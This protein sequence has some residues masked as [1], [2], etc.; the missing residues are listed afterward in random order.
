[1]IAMQYAATNTLTFDIP[2]GFTGLDLV[3]SFLSM[4]GNEYDFDADFNI[5]SQTTDPANPPAQKKCGW[6]GCGI[7]VYSINTADPV[8]RY[9]L[10]ATTG[11]PHGTI[12]FKCIV[13]SLTWKSK[14]S[15]QWNAFTVG[16]VGLA[17]DVAPYG[18]PC[19]PVTCQAGCKDATGGCTYTN[20]FDT[21]LCDDNNVCTSGDICSNG[22]CQGT[23]NTDSCYDNDACT[24][25]DT[26][27]GGVCQG[28]TKDC[29]TPSDPQCQS[30]VGTCD[31]SSGD[32]SY[33]SLTDG[34]SCNAD[35]NACTPDAC[36]NGACTSGPTKDCNTPSDPQ[37]Q[38]N[39][40]TCDTS[41]GDCS[42]SSLTDG[43]S[44]NADN[45]ACT[46]GDAC[47]AGVCQ[48][49]PQKMCNTPPDQCKND[50]GTCVNGDCSYGNKADGTTC[51]DGND[52]T[53]GDTCQSGTCTAGTYVCCRTTG[54][55]HGGLCGKCVHDCNTQQSC[56]DVLLF[57]GFELLDWLLAPL[58]TCL[59]GPHDCDHIP[60][61]VC[62]APLS[63]NGIS[64]SNGHCSCHNHH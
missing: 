1:M 58:F 64:Y 37:C 44:C 36:Q 50:I 60:G 53:S 61:T 41:S 30:S 7:A 54:L 14:V 43:T 25:G 42:Y 47:S 5:L 11:E 21:T 39:E 17:E 32:C 19:D 51:D 2:A 9:G 35:N 52:C 13:N 12:Q 49:G 28:T 48:S 33:S 26:C 18:Q 45:N 56:K 34:T 24:L 3:Y 29:N 38:N 59:G 20:V 15:E 62:C 16:V 63:Q 46:L 22:F 8:Y 27:S 23:A 31:T 6:F 4:N 55:L 10:K 40:G 57:F